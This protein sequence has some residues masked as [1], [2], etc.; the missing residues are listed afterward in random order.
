MAAVAP[1]GMPPPPPPPPPG[2]RKPTSKAAPRP[3]R[4]L[5]KCPGCDE[6]R[7]LEEFQEIFGGGRHTLCTHCLNPQAGT[8]E[9]A[10]GD[11][12]MTD[13]E[14]ASE[15][16]AL[17][18]G[19]DSA[20][21][22]SRKN[23]KNNNREGNASGLDLTAQQA[24]SLSAV[25]QTSRALAPALDPSAQQESSSSTP[26]PDAVIEPGLQDDQ[27]P[28]KKRRMGFGLT[29][30]CC[31]NILAN[32]YSNHPNGKGFIC[33]ICGR[34][35]RCAEEYAKLRSAPVDPAWEDEDFF[36]PTSGIA[37]GA[38][39][40]Q[41][42]ASAEASFASD[43][44]RLRYRHGPNYWHF[45][46]DDL[47]NLSNERQIFAAGPRKDINL[48]R[49]QLADAEQGLLP[50]PRPLPSR[51]HGMQTPVLRSNARQKKYSRIELNAESN[52]N[53]ELDTTELR[54]SMIAHCL[55][56]DAQEN[57]SYWATMDETSRQ[58]LIDILLDDLTTTLGLRE[59]GARAHKL[60]NRTLFGEPV[61]YLRSVHVGGITGITGTDS[62][63]E[64]LDAQVRNHRVSPNPTSSLG[65]LCGVRA[66]S[67]S[68]HDVRLR[69]ARLNDR[70]PPSQI[71]H[72]DMMRLL[73]QNWDAEEQYEAGQQGAPT[74]ENETFIRRTYHD[75]VGA[76]NLPLLRNEMLTMNN[77][78]A[79]QLQ[80]VLTLL[81]EN[82]TLGHHYQL[83]V[84]ASAHVGEASGDRPAQDVAPW[85][86]FVN[87][88]LPNENAAGGN[89]RPVLFVHNNI[90]FGGG[91]YNHFEGMVEGG[92]IHS[93]YG[94]GIYI[95]GAEEIMATR[96]WNAEFMEVGT[97]DDC[98]WPNVTINPG[99]IEG[100]PTEE[101][102]RRFDNPFRPENF[103]ANQWAVDP[104]TD[105][106]H[107][108]SIFVN[109][110][111]S[112]PGAAGIN[113]IAIDQQQ[114]M[115]Q[116][117]NM[118]NGGLANPI[119]NHP[120]GTRPLG[121][122]SVMRKARFVFARHGARAVPTAV[123][124]VQDPAVLRMVGLIDELFGKLAPNQNPPDEIQFVLGGLA[125]YS[126]GVMHWG[127]R[128]GGFFHYVSTL[129]AQ[130]ADRI[131]I[132]VLAELPVVDGISASSLQG[133]TNVTVPGWQY[134]G[135]KMLHKAKL[136]DL[137]DRYEHRQAT[138]LALAY[139]LAP[140]PPLP[141]I[142][143]QALPNLDMLIDAMGDDEDWRSGRLDAMTVPTDVIVDQRNNNRNAPMN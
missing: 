64:A 63:L 38:V 135:H 42:L 27:P 67:D 19:N 142:P 89:Q 75:S 9:G 14:D 28:A 47:I 129:D 130:L 21:P 97:E 16:G 138:A 141:H 95:G 104:P 53:P 133:V 87:D 3:S 85:V 112:H 32:Q 45:S 11:V 108:I 77:L 6:D 2:K 96:F 73:F 136:A 30:A 31:K 37:H 48:Q 120:E 83:G 43:D 91:I 54:E 41:D 25:R 50:V 72:E 105:E 143:I 44:A 140:P 103:V 26:V 82:R 70:P 10:D 125:G 78:D 139:N 17:G 57:I 34:R 131:F 33:V 134:H 127:S 71:T 132:V 79:D 128:T 8:L 123:G 18:A 84:I 36:L 92:D 86:R 101:S 65:W 114:T 94:W 24:D 13:V 111:S 122:G 23:C 55:R 109:R 118:L 62:A 40:H 60:R 88:F 69:D 52:D 20:D 39:M 76:E 51:Y 29:C 98:E 99:F 59:Q 56:F 102:L 1:G 12:E 49:L 35:L 110:A 113:A 117:N 15:E 126:V 81:H 66:L 7:S 90:A 80:A 107:F 121:V 93:I 115:V 58:A 116:Y 46:M 119:S 5:I 4:K 106:K 68:L 22:N 100:V 61:N 74:P 124:N 137:V